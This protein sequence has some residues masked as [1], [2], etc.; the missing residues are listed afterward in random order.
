[1]PGAQPKFADGIDY[2]ETTIIGM[3]EQTIGSVTVRI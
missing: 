2:S 3:G 1:M